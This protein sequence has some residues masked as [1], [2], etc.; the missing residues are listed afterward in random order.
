MNKRVLGGICEFISELIFII[1]LAFMDSGKSK[2][3]FIISFV[4]MAVCLL[5]RFTTPKINDD[6]KDKSND[7]MLE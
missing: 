5:L 1:A 3:L 2:I 4:F 6:T 7:K